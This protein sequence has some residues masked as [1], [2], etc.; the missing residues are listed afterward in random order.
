MGI[1]ALAPAVSEDSNHDRENEGGG[2]GRN[3]HELCAD[4]TITHAADD[5]GR[6]VCQAE[7]HIAREEE[8]ESE[9]KNLAE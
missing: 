7:N 4:S 3:R 6:E 8:R 9:N 5:G 1:A 2:I